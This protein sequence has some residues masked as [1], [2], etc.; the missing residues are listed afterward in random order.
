MTD[1]DETGGCC[2]PILYTLAI[3]VVLVVIA[4]GYAIATLADR[5][6]PWPLAR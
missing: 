1:T 4:W 3:L 5:P 2:G 6:A